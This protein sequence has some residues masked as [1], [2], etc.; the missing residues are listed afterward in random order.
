MAKRVLIHSLVFN[1][2]GVSTAYLYGDIALALKNRGFD[3]VVLTTTPHYNQVPEQLKKQPLKWKIWGILKQSTFQGITVYHVPQK[4]FK[5]TILR[6]FGF[7]Y[8]HLISFLS[9][10]F[11]KKV[12]VI[13]SPSPPLTIGLLNVWIG[14][15][16]KCNVIYNVQEVYPDILGK[17][18]GIV[19]NVLSKIE[20]IVYDSSSAVTTIDQVFYDTIVGRFKEKRK[21][22]I[23]PNFVDDDMYKPIDRRNISLDSKIFQVNNNIKLLY[24]GNIGMAQ[25]WDTLIELAKLAK[26]HPYDFY[27][28]GEGVKKEY[29]NNSITK[30]GLD[31]VKLI[32]Y[33]SRELIPRII[34]FSDIQFIFMEPEIAAQGFPSKVYTIMA[35]GRPLLVCSPDNTPIIN[36][37]KK[38]G[39]AKLVTDSIAK[40]KAEQIFEWLQTV[41]SRDLEDMGRHGENEIKLRYSKAIVTKQYCDLIDNL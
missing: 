38:I 32:P 13:V 15:L 11:I 12:D 17:N 23:I 35:C 22:H 39:C 25:D 14:K 18:T 41:S 7:V 27:V 26:G 24:A 9:A 30:F 33:Q 28:I 21:L 34:A 29:L 1:P 19:Y 40:V 8:W 10:L 3:V 37:L 16:K 4:K 5:S 31:N 2:D 6:L 20:K 36:F